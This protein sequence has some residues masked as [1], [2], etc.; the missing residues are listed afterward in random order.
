MLKQ[1]KNS[2]SYMIP[3][4]VNAREDNFT[5]QCMSNYELHFFNGKY[6]IINN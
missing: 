4:G 5:N 6:I 1:N 3:L 2:R